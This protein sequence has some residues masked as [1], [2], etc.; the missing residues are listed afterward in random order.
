MLL[1]AAFTSVLAAGSAWSADATRSSNFREEDI[2][3]KAFVLLS[4][5]NWRKPVMF[6]HYGLYIT[7]IRRGPKDGTR[8]KWLSGGVRPARFE[9]R[10]PQYDGNMTTCRK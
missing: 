10:P 6:K 2:G 3:V 1:L 4:T 8:Q 9:R 5:A 7:M